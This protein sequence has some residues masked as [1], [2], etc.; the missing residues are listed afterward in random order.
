[1]F[2]QRAAFALARRA[3]VRAFARRTFSSSVVRSSKWD[4]KPGEPQ[5]KILPYDEIKTEADL[6]GPGAEPGTIGTDLEQSTGLERLELLGK[7]EG[8]DIFNMKPLDASRLGTLDNPILVKSGGPE[9]YV[10]CTGYPADSHNVIWLTV[11]RDRP[12]ERCSECGNCIK[13]DYIGPKED[14][15][16]HAEVYEPKT[17]ADYVKP[18][19][20][21]R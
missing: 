1:M 14:D 7:M 9:Q 15:H 3:P 8:V 20:W 19:Y 21:Y 11:S 17:M 4:P 5:G 10:G 2:V 18:E 6:I 13:M 16:H 12:L